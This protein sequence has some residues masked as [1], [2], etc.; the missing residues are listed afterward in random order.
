MGWA[1]WMVV[2]QS[3]EEELELE[4]SVRGIYRCDGV[5]EIQKLCESLVRQNWH[6]TKLLK[7][8]VHHIAEMDASLVCGETQ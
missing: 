8:A 3:L 4:R 2:N 7:Q 6:Q 1:D 5:E